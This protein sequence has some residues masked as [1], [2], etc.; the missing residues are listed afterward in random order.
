MEALVYLN[1]RYLEHHELGSVDLT[2]A[3]RIYLPPAMLND[4]ELLWCMRASIGPGAPVTA[5][6]LGQRPQLS[7]LVFTFK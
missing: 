6:R 2:Q 7:T 1:G 5:G 3:S 4:D